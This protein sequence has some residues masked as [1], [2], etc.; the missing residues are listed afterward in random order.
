MLTKTPVIGDS[1]VIIN[2]RVHGSAPRLVTINKI[3]RQRIYCSDEVFTHKGEHIKSFSCYELWDSLEAY[4]SEER[5]KRLIALIRSQA[6]TWDF[7]Q[8]IDVANLEK[9]LELMK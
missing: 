2:K 9:I 1:V 4:N 6:N 5:K 3:T 8:D 7:G